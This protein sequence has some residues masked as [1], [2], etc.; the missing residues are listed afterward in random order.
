MTYK[1]NELEY[2]ALQ[3]ITYIN[4]MDCWFCLKTNKH[5]DDYIYDLEEHKRLS[6]KAALNYIHE[7]LLQEDFSQLSKMEQRALNN[8]FLRYRLSIFKEGF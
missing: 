4:K 3:N 6:L 2:N 7:G 8:M 5:G 1:L